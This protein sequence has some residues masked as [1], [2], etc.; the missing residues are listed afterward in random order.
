L[1]QN[2]KNLLVVAKAVVCVAR[3]GR[4][5]VWTPN[6][7]GPAWGPVDEKIGTYRFP[8][9]FNI[10]PHWCHVVNTLRHQARSMPM[11]QISAVS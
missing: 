3:I 8:T 10:L 11:M 9:V 5:H 2:L 6:E 4:V 7:K 1:E